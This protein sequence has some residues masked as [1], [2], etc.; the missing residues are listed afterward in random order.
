[1]RA[2]GIPPA[3]EVPRRVGGEIAQAGT[4][5]AGSRVSRCISSPCPST[6]ASARPL[7][8]A[9]TRPHATGSA[10]VCLSGAA[11]TAAALANH[12]AGPARGPGTRIPPWRARQPGPRLPACRTPAGSQPPATAG[13]TRAAPGSGPQPRV[14]SAAPRSRRPSRPSQPCSRPV[15]ADN[16]VIA[17]D[18]VSCALSR[19]ARFGIR[20]RGS[21]AVR[22]FQCS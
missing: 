12:R 22:Q 11:R 7:I 8:P 18:L 6:R 16:S 3:D 19:T 14:R 17:A 9:S 13:K 15:G 4:L 21:Y 1:M 10:A 2:A 20:L 5:P